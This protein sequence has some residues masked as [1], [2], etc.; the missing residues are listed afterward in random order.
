LTVHKT[1]RDGAMLY[2]PF[3]AT[4]KL[5]SELCLSRIIPHPDQTAVAMEEDNN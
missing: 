5:T 3:A 4:G 2:A 1:R